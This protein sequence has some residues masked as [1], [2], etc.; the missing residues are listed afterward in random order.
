M[1]KIK[2]RAVSDQLKE[3]IQT[4]HHPYNGAQ[5]IVLLTTT[6]WLIVD[7]ANN[8]LVASRGPASVNEKGRHSHS[9]LIGVKTGL[10]ALGI[11]LPTETRRRKS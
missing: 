5:Y 10:R 1:L 2:Y 8:S 7:A 9:T 3:S 11:V 4:L 6:E